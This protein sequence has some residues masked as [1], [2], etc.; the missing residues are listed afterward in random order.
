VGRL[1]RPRACFYTTT[2]TPPRVLPAIIVR[3][4]NGGT[5]C[6]LAVLYPDESIPRQLANV[7]H[8]TGPHSWCWPPLR[9]K[10]S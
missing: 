8:G 3:T 4:R 6:D 2:E 7:P 5:N 10:L 9:E 1:H